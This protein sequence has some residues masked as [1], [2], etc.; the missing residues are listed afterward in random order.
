MLTIK[1]AVR[2]NRRGRMALSGPSGTGKT[3][4][5]LQIAGQ[6][7]KKIVVIDT[8]HESA[9]LYA[10]EKCPIIGTPFEFDT[11]PLTSFSPENYTKAIELCESGGYDVCIIDSLS[12][13]WM[14]KD[15]ALERVDN[16]AKRSMRNDQ[17]AGWRDVTP[18]HNQLVE[19]MLAC[20]MHLIVTMRVKTEIAEEKNE[21]GKTVLRKIGLKPVQREGL[22]YEFDV[23]ADLTHEQELIIDKTRCSVLKNKIY[24]EDGISLGKTFN[25]WLSGGAPEEP[26]PAP[27]ASPDFERIKSLIKIAKDRQALDVAVKEA[28]VAIRERKIS[29]EESDSLHTLYKERKRE[30]GSEVTP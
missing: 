8:E 17:R 30:L 27:E 3:F 9:S 20:R 11:V 7:G 16:I 24:R 6:L 14:G 26:V 21:K 12:H 10:G 29:N 23:T 5:A 25:A 2:R 1:K 22:E 28:S 13:A 19:A 18:Q 15:G 4:T